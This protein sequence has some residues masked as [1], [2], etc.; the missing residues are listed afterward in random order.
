[1]E[2]LARV[3][4]TD[5]NLLEAIRNLRIQLEQLDEIEKLF[6]EMQYWPA[7]VQKKVPQRLTISASQLGLIFDGDTSRNSVNVFL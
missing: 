4:T 3:Y 5:I 2:A 7:L 6:E 1:M